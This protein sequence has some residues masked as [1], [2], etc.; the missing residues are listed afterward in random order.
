MLKR[1]FGAFEIRPS[2]KTNICHFRVDLVHLLLHVPI[3]IINVSG[4][5]PRLLITLLIAV[6]LCASG[7][8]IEQQH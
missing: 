3:L 1:P 6:F 7:R 4:A 5:P 8:C 2:L